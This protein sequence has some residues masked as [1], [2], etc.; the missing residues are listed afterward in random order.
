MSEV[1]DRRRECI[2]E[3]ADRLLRAG[4]EP[5][6]KEIEAQLAAITRDR[7]VS[8]SGWNHRA[9]IQDVRSA[10]YEKQL[11][12]TIHTFSG[13]TRVRLEDALKLME[14]AK[15]LG[16][17]MTHEPQGDGEWF[18][19]WFENGQ[20]KDGGIQSDDTV[21]NC[22]VRAVISWNASRGKKGR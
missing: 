1:P 15:A 21:G 18:V 11:D 20:P 16:A 13:L 22:I 12:S 7:G 9:T 10:Y 19:E 17:R 8:V 5:S 3:A 6:D 2:E 4:V 14:V